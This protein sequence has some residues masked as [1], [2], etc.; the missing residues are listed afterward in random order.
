MSKGRVLIVDDS[1]DNRTLIQHYVA[2]MGFE[3]E[4]AA[5]GTEAIERVRT[6][7]YD[8]ILLDVQMPGLD[9]F[10][11]LKR[12][13]GA[14]YDGIVVALTAHTLE[15]DRE[16]C[17]RSG[18]DDFVPKPLDREQLRRALERGARGS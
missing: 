6:V 14:N 12:L 2:R 8:V 3:P 5:S 10:E 18:F 4:T 7:Q 1:P 13:R 9:G 16:A 17:L 11:T 15:G